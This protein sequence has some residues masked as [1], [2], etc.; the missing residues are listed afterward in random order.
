MG[1][2]GEEEWPVPADCPVLVG[3]RKSG[4]E[5]EAQLEAK[6]KLTNFGEG[7]DEESKKELLS[8]LGK[9]LSVKVMRD[10]S[11]K[12]R[13][14]VDYEKHEDATKSVEEMDGK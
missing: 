14:F 13:G 11:G 12:P 5:Q 8:Q 10:P 3:R 4:K 2:H 7:M 1:S 6:P 9:T